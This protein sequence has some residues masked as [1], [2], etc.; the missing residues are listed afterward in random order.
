MDRD[1]LGTRMKERYEMRSQTYLPRRTYTILRLDGKAFHTLTKNCVRPFD[2][3]LMN[4]MDQ[5]AKALCENIQGAQFAYTQSDEISILLTDF[6]K[7]NTEA[8]FDGN[9]QKICSVSASMAS[10]FFNSFKQHVIEHLFTNIAFFDSRCFTIS[11][12]IEVANYFIWR[13]K[14][15]TRNSISMVAQSMYSHKELHGK[16]T[17][18]MQEMIHQKGKNWNDYQAGSKR[19]RMVVYEEPDMDNVGYHRS[20]WVVTEPPVFTQET[21]YLKKL[22]PIHPDFELKKGE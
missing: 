1:D 14:D 4:L 8:Y 6:E 2:F 5:V 7:I 22:I 20:I 3:G 16:N 18:D 11:D 13:Q 17:S 9:I 12:P 15:A 19:G 21:Y 10:G